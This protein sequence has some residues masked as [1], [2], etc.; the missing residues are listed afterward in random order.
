MRVILCQPFKGKAKEVEA[1]G[2]RLRDRFIRFLVKL[3]RHEGFAL[4]DRTIP[5][6]WLV[7]KFPGISYNRILIEPGY[8]GRALEKELRY[9]M[10]METWP[11]C[12][13]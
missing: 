9:E 13:Y 10:A 3:Y 5:V 12:W 4:I 11:L 7:G 2:F 6:P 8:T 1:A